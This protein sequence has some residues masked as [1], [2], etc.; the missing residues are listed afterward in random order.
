MDLAT[1]NGGSFH[2][3]VNV[4]QRV[5]DMVGNIYTYI[6]IYILV[7]GLEC[8]EHDFYDFP[9]IWDVIIPTDFHI[10]SEGLIYNQPVYTYI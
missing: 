10:F 6:Y 8:L 1:Q 4:Y 5:N 7:G 2:S 9:Y 3:Y